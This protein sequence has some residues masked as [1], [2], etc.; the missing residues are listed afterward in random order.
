MP[1]AREVLAHA[2]DPATAGRAAL[3]ADTRRRTWSQLAD[4]VRAGAVH[5]QGAGTVAGDL[6]AVSIADPVD[7]VVAMLAVDLLGATALVCDPTWTRPHRAEVLRAVEPTTFCDVALPRGLP[8]TAGPRDAP[9]P[10]D[11]DRPW[12]GFSSGS[13][14]RPRA[15]VRTRA[16]WAGSFGAAAALTGTRP[17]DVVVVPG[18][19]ASSLYCFATVHALATGASVRFARGGASLVAALA[20]GCVVHTVPADAVEVLDAIEAGA[21]SALRTLVVG[22]ASLPEG[23]RERADR[24]GIATFA[25]YGAVEL[26][27]VAYDDDGAGLRAFPG[28][29]LDVRP[30]PGSRL[31]QVWVRSPWVALGYLARASGPFVREGGWASVGDLAEAPGGPGQDAPLVLR[32][33]GDGAILTGGATVVPEDVE[34]VL[35]RV[36]G[37]RDVVV[38]GTAHRRLGAVVTAVVECDARPG[39]RAHLERVARSNLAPAQR[40]RRWYG[41]RTLPRTASGKA[42]RAAVSELLLDGP[43]TLEVLR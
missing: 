13:T 35:R 43:G 31:G 40:P 42:A 39:L 19:L 41:V 1:V 18:P 9:A 37:V 6:V 2:A 33:R 26:S 25:Y 22:G 11:D 3:L 21:P 38:V 4:D 12:A 15:V 8:G 34:V 30:T 17:G 29:E 16:S 7:A 14:G 27:F 23:V 36:P 20:D 10:A 32:G 24:R 5:L 28:V